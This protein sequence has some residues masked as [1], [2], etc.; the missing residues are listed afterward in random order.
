MQAKRNLGTSRLTT[1]QCTQH[2]ATASA[3]TAE[4]ISKWGWLKMSAGGASF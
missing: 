2:M 4:R 1:T 3:G